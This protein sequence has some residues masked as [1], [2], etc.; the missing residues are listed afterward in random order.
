MVD[1]LYGDVVDSTSGIQRGVECK[2]D[3]QLLESG[4]RRV[5]CDAVVCPERRLAQ[6]TA[7]GITTK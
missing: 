6:I 5:H 2:F 3:A 1:A 7:Y 4:K